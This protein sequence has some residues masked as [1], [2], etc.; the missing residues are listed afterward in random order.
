MKVKA[1]S[2]TL[3]PLNRNLQFE[4]SVKVLLTLVTAW[5]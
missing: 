2:I 3:Q 5:Y 4:K 1:Q